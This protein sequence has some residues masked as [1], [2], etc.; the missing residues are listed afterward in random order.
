MKLKIDDNDP[1]NPFG[2]VKTVAISFVAHYDGPEAWNQNIL[3][4]KLEALLKEHN[5][6]LQTYKATNYWDAAGNEITEDDMRSYISKKH[7]HTYGK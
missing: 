5:Y 7:G 2:K 6:S 3:V 1:A 4:N